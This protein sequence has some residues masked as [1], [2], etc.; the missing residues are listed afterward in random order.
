MRD[1]SRSAALVT[2]GG[3]GIGRGVALALARRGY[4]VALAGR[5]RD[6]LED[7]CRRAEEAG[8]TAAFAL[9]CDLADAEQRAALWEQAR[10]AFGATPRVLVHSAGA[11]AGGAL[12]ELSGEEERAVVGANLLGPLALTRL[13]L[14]DLRWQRDGAVVFVGSM[15]ALVPPPGAAVYAAT[16]AAVHA[17]A[18]ALVVECAGSGV[19][20]LN[21]IP[22]GTATD[23]TRWMAEACDGRY[24]LADP[25][26]VGERI[27]RAVEARRSGELNLMAP[28][29]RLLVA[30]HRAV[31][32][33]IRSLLVGRRDELLRMMRGPRD[34]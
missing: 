33:L 32:G 1:L 14:P 3:T 27:V 10:A 24:P 4:A 9:P 13:A 20:V 30:L 31:P 5:R 21:V 11:L 19:R 34:E 17:L 15:T 8:A 16:K 22:P 28:P 26:V 2:G 23:M 6:L 25:A 12:A 7:A 18:A 29:E